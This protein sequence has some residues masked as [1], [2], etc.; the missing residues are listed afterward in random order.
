MSD[1]NLM[2]QDQQ[3]K[4]QSKHHSTLEVVEIEKQGSG[5]DWQTM[6]INA[7]AVVGAIAIIYVIFT[8]IS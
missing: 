3:R 1:P 2:Q 7:L 8:L 4:A 5:S 6:A